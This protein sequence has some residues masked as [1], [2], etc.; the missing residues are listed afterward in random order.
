M[1]GDLQNKRFN[2]MFRLPD[3]TLI[4]EINCSLKKAIPHEGI[5]YVSQNFLCFSATTFGVK[6]REVIKFEDINDIELKTK[7]IDI[8]IKSEE[9]YSFTN[10]EDHE[11]TFDFI[12]LLWTKS[13][14]SL[15]TPNLALSGSIRIVTR[16]SSFFN[17]T[18][19]NQDGN[20]QWV[21]PD[22]NDWK[23]LLKGTRSLTFK[24]DEVIISEGKESV[25]LFQLCRGECRIVQPDSNKVL[26]YISAEDDDPLLGEI[27]FLEGRLSTAW[28][29]ADSEEVVVRVLEAYYLN[30]LF[31]L[32]PHIAPRFY[33]Y[34]AEVLYNR[35]KKRGLI[36]TEDEETEKL[37]DDD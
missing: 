9:M 11:G 35:I 27:S 34:L 7:S 15:E 28:V 19:N 4:R 12:Y 24:K 33:R 3:E 10:F 26:G 25:G 1:D 5:L 16:E 32:Y 17:V 37:K 2:K 6:L 36:S 31:Q 14:P 23:Y 21:N 20:F 30:V 22:E 29:I 8:T 18:Y 13:S